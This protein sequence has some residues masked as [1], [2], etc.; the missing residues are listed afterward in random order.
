[1]FGAADRREQYATESSRLAASGFGRISEMPS[2]HRTPEPTN[3]QTEYEDLAAHDRRSSLG[4]DELERYGIAAYLTGHQAF[5]IDI[6][7]R[8]H[9]AA[10]ERGDTRLAARA[11]FWIAFALL[12]AREP[13]RA[14]GWVARCRRLLEEE[15]QDC[16]ERGYVM[17]PSVLLLVG[18][19]DLVGAEAGF[20]SAE[21]IGTRF[22]DRD[23]T[24]LARQGRGRALIA[25]GRT[26][27]GLALFDEVMVS[28]TAGEV[29]PI[30]AGV[31]YCSV[32]SQ[33][34]D[35]LDIRRAQE[36]TTA[37]ND[38]CQAQP[39]LVPYKG[40]CLAHR[41]EILTL[42]GRWADA[43]DEAGHACD[44]LVSA[45]GPGPG[46]AAYGLGELHRLRGDVAAAEDAYARASEHGRLPYPGLALLRLAQGQHEVARAAIEHAM[47][48]PLRGRQRANLLSGA[49]EILIATGD[50]AAAGRAAE[51]LEAIAARFETPWLRAM[52]AS[53]CGAVRVADGSAH[54]ALTPLREAAAI[55]RDLDAPYE[56]ARVSVLIGRA[57]QAL[58]DAD[59]ARME[60]EAAARSF[61]QLGAS[62]ALGELGSLMN[63]QPP[64]S[65]D[66]GNLSPREVEV[67]RLIARGYTNRLIG[68]K[69]GISEKTVARHISNIFIKLDLTSRAAATA[70]AFTHG[71]VPG[72]VAT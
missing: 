65:A 56:V 61:R 48:E 70:Y 20:A 72:S 59:G 45:K 7:T 49:V 4:P 10:L 29:T 3:W 28:V 18:Q 41:A 42:R 71:L 46:T 11:A 60:W 67:L 30:V 47:A 50:A 14:A 26:S 54:E 32:I 31:V 16:V 34:F 58:G 52:S 64:L 6:C 37:L 5:S 35:M 53:A 19:G 9:N 36:W 2:T 24:S 66:S 44:A 1:M 13:A 22:G 23:L 33:C 57:C 68:R 69:L 21:A 51:E 12:D 39:S 27:E 15:G 62:P 25:L 8:A 40:E 43:L 63:R 17:L 38:W 55:W